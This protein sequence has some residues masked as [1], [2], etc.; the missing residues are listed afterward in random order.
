MTKPRMARTTAAIV[1][2]SLR[3]CA[4]LVMFTQVSLPGAQ[5][6]C[7]RS[8]CGGGR[9]RAASHDLSL[10]LEPSDRVSAGL[11]HFSV[12]L[13]AC[14]GRASWGTVCADLPWRSC[15]PTISPRASAPP[16]GPVPT[17][18][19]GRSSVRLPRP[20]RTWRGRAP[21]L[22]SRSGTSTAS[23]AR[24]SGSSRSSSSYSASRR[25]RSSRAGSWRSRWRS[26]FTPT[27]RA[28][29][30]WRCRTS[31]TCCCTRKTARACCTAWRS[32]C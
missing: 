6:P 10:Q 18:S 1:S 17:P 32:A 27:G 4:I 2:R 19:Q 22:A 31:A 14:G 8:V 15:L 11:L 20:S 12:P 30:G 21:S 7:G 23:P 26:G 9:C 13:G 3:G 16:Q 24:S 29:A 5:R 25:R 28:S